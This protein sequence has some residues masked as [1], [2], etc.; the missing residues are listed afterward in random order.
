[1]AFAL[2]NPIR[3]GVDRGVGGGGGGGGQKVPALSD[4]ER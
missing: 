1:M 2:F 3:P 4:F